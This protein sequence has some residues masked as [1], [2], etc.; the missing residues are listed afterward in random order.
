[1]TKLKETKLA[2]L[3]DT[4]YVLDPKALISYDR[5][6]ERLRVSTEASFP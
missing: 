1:M 6:L 5:D 3:I 4:I 2:W